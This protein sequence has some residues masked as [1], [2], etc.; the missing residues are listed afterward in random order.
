[1]V[2]Y[3]SEINEMPSAEDAMGLSWLILDEE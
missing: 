2:D 3:K 1:M